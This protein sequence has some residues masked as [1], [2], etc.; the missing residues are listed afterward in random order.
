MSVPG[1]RD[2]GEK[3]G[4]ASGEVFISKTCQNCFSLKIRCDRTQRAD[5][6]DRCARLGKQCLFRPAR[7]RD[8]SA[9]RDTRI[10]ALEAQVQ[11]L[12]RTQTPA[13]NAQQPLPPSMPE[14]PAPTATIPPAL[15]SA[16]A[17]PII[18]IPIPEHT[19]VIDD[20]IL[21]LE[22]AD[23]LVEMYRVEMMP[24]FPFII[25]HET[26][27][28]MR[29]EK[30]FLFLAILSVA[31]FHDL[32]AQEKLGERLKREVTEKVFYG[33]DDCLKLEYLQGLLILLA[34][35][36]YHGQ[37]K[38]YSQ[39]LHLAISIAVDM[40]LDRRPLQTRPKPA[41]NK[42]DPLQ[43]SALGHPG[44]QT[45]GSDE[46]RAAAGLFYL[47]STISKLLDKMIMFPCTKT[48]EDGCLALGQVGEYRT[49]KD[50]YHVIKL[51]QIIENIESL[52]K[53]PHSETDAQIAYLRVRD[54]LEAFRVYLNSDFS[55]SHLLFMQF[56]TAKLFLY[57]VAFF[58]RN[59]QSSPHHHLPIL[60][61]GL[62]SAKSFLDL[63]LW[64]PPKSEMS[65][66]NSEWIQ[67]SFGV[68][69]AAKFAI[70]SKAPNVEPQTRELRHRLNIEHVFR[71][72]TLRIGALVGRAGPGGDKRKDIFCYYEQRVRK[73]Q[74]WYEGMTRA[75][76]S[77]TPSSNHS[78]TSQHLH[79][80]QQR[81]SYVSPTSLPSHPQQNAQQ[82]T[83][84][85]VSSQV[86]LSSTFSHQQSTFSQPA[87]SYSASNMMQAPA[88]PAPMNAYSTYASSPPSIAFPDLMNAPGWDA[89]FAVP[90][91]DTNW[92]MMDLGVT[93]PSDAGWGDG[94]GNV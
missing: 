86:P 88:T 70:I 15:P 42:R 10:Q 43:K 77:D 71:H 74:T 90:M 51:Q 31:S 20:D 36:Q 40:R 35:N 93:P 14:R 8:N 21:T 4:T 63:Y 1:A 9:K 46:Q 65:L 89:L 76:R 27:H 22:R 81:S 66:T 17:P 53:D 50:L 6:C 85:A 7:R 34:W 72:L 25:V 61:S 41:N 64:L 23:T 75:T 69:Q 38:F 56:H 68:T 48:I 45:W 62:E 52:A 91:E 33:G 29:Y 87:A 79:Q 44:P 60:C 84:Q 12:L 5:I 16:N 13:H 58:E 47:S 57:Q 73:I 26:G 80:P 39:Y 54:E 24:H 49:D 19:D 67:L 28:K 94:S 30:P 2:E 55:D 83:R 3:G 18:P 37:S 32:Q 92:S 78:M 59:L 11:N 82:H